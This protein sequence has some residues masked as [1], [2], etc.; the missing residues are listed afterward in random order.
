MQK[1]WLAGYDEVNK[2]YE[3]IISEHLHPSFQFCHEVINPKNLW[4]QCRLTPN[5]LREVLF[6]RTKIVQITTSEMFLNVKVCNSRA[7]IVDRWILFLYTSLAGYNKLRPNP[8]WKFEGK[9]VWILLY[10]V[11]VSHATGEKK[12]RL[13]R[14]CINR[15][16][17]KYSLMICSLEEN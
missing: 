10:S 6:A 4:T 2:N 14:K 9:P 17:W 15:R 12:I 5:T 3:N 13:E 8:V 11:N 7:T 1:S 16:A